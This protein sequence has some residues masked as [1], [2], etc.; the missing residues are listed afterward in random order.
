MSNTY[1]QIHIQFVFAVKHRHSLIGSSWK[2]ELYQYI[3]GIVQNNNHKLVAINGT[4]DHIHILIGVRPHQSIASLMQEVKANSSRWINEKKFIKEK[5]EWQSGYG[6]FSYGKSQ[7]TN[8]IV[9]IQNQEQHHLKKTFL[10][11]YKEFLEKFE[12]DYDEKYIFQELL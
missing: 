4:A 11:E 7:L 2:N 5:F 6:A 1:T 8:V 3:T 9:Y 10:Q 12:I